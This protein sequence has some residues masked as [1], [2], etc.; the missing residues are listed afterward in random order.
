MHNLPAMKGFSTCIKVV[1][2]IN[3]WWKKQSAAV[4]AACQ[5][6]AILAAKST[7]RKN[8]PL[9]PPR[10]YF[11]SCYQ[12]FLVKYSSF[13]FSRPR[14]LSESWAVTRI[15]QLL[16]RRQWNKQN[17]IQR[18]KWPLESVVSMLLTFLLLDFVQHSGKVLLC[19]YVFT[20]IV[21]EGGKMAWGGSPCPGNPFQRL[22]IHPQAAQPLPTMANPTVLLQGRGGGCL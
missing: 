9:L 10:I 11:W 21:V 8:K 1:V 4:P 12:S 14:C 17:D 20:E 15:S 18:E 7:G 16:P 3:G 19:W 6:F 2:S 13:V 5:S 22:E